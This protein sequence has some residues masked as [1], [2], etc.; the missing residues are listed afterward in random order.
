MNFDPNVLHI[1]SFVLPHLSNPKYPLP[2]QLI[3]KLRVIHFTIFDDKNFNLW[4]Q[5][6]PQ[7]IFKS[8]PILNIG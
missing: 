2:P 6:G 8:S 4:V 7:V 3:E 1:L 5:R